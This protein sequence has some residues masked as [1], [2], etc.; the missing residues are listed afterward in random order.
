MVY[1]L[2][3]AVIALWIILQPVFVLDRAF[4][5]EV[6]ECYN[7]S[8]LLTL[9]FVIELCFKYF[10]APNSFW[11]FF[12]TIEFFS[13]AGILFFANLLYLLPNDYRD[14]EIINY[15]SV[16]LL[17]GLFCLMKFFRLI[18]F[19]MMRVEL[20]VIFKSIVDVLP[21]FFE[22]LMIVAFVN[23]IYSIIAQFLWAG[24]VN[25]E[26]I[27]KY[28]EATGDVIDEDYL[29]INFN[30]AL[31][32]FYYFMDYGLRGEYA[33]LTISLMVL[34]KVRDPTNWKM[35]A[36]KL[37]GYSYM[38]IMEFSIMNI[39]ITFVGAIIGLY[40]EKSEEDIQ[41]QKEQIRNQTLI[42]ALLEK[43]R[44]DGE[45]RSDDEDVEYNED[46]SANREPEKPP[47]LNSLEQEVDEE[48]EDE[49]GQ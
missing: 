19:L 40:E 4:I 22:I 35:V 21:I 29:K 14:K 37:F 31:S 33:D 18:E 12:N 25:T 47:S 32:A 11:S 20:K 13:S 3:F 7:F 16:F 24:L 10:A 17:W 6:T 8:S 42:D 36:V 46:E 23:L 27:E 45:P 26:F 9:I 1:N 38:I 43:P 30:D 41:K 39:L 44:F 48:N 28:E 49:M 5:N 15:F 2:F 34:Q